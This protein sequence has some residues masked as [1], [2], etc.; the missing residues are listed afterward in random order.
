MSGRAALFVLL[1]A[2]ILLLCSLAAAQSQSPPQSITDVR[3]TSVTGCVDVYPITVNC[4]T[5]RNRLRIQTAGFPAGIDF[6]YLFVNAEINDNAG[7]AANYARPDLSDPTNSSLFVNVTARSYYPHITGTVINVSF[8]YYGA[9]PSQTSPAFAA[10]SYR[11]DGPPTL[12]S[13]AGCD[14]SGQ[15]TLNCVPDSAV[16]TLTG[17]G[18]LWYSVGKTARLSIGNETSRPSF[19]DLTVIND[20]YAKLSLQRA[21]PELLKPQHYAGVLLPLN[22]TSYVYNSSGQVVYTYTTNSLHISFVSLPPP[23]IARK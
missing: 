1:S 8:S 6:R 10:F 7:F 22:L 14:G 17:S 18:L 11:F 19:S 4:S 23:I 20:T 21:Y 12:T 13:I 5:T 9:S 3:V 2:T 15:A 16:L